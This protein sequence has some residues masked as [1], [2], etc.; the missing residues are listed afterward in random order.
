M[1]DP[2]D[3][4]RREES[5]LSSLWQRAP[6]WRATVAG[7]ALATVAAT[8]FWAEAHLSGSA[9]VGVP[10][11]AATPVRHAQDPQLPESASSQPSRHTGS[12][13]PGSASAEDEQTEAIC[14]PH[15]LRAPASMPQ[16]DVA[17]MPEPNLGHIKVHF[18]V[19]GAGM[20]TREVL[21]AATFGT[22]AEQQA[23]TGYTRELTFA[24]PNT[25]ECQ[26]REVEV[27]GDFFERRDPGG[28]WATYVRLYPRF[29]FDNTGVLRHAD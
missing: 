25:K 14:H 4:S 20:V 28:Q 9:V 2:L 3:R 16:I 18:W 22:V 12:D 13:S 5:T 1:T 19:N 26:G 24:L 29:T 15:L 11:S 23:E 8:V 17:K 10:A 27:I 21:T 6:W 7:A